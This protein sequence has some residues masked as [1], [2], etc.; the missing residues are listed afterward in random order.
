MVPERVADA[1]VDGSYDQARPQRSSQLGYPLR[2]PGV[3]YYLLVLGGIVAALTEAQVGS[4]GSA[5]HRSST[6]PAAARGAE[7][8]EGIQNPI[9]YAGWLG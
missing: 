1:E 7:M 2:P 3:D 6:G 9:R 8:P 4:R 5:I